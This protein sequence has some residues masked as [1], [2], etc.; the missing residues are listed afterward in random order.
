MTV[1]GI[2]LVSKLSYIISDQNFHTC[3]KALLS[4]DGSTSPRTKNNV[5]KNGLLRKSTAEQGAV[6]VNCKYPK[7]YSKMVK[8]A[9]C[10]HSALI[11]YIHC[12]CILYVI[13]FLNFNDTLRAWLH[14]GFIISSEKL[15]TLRHAHC[16]CLYQVQV[17]YNFPLNLINSTEDISPR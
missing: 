5:V 6:I 4:K 17:R 12:L 16:C 10:T 8:I 1:C 13:Y 2:Q 9:Q 14:L 7:S 3:V 15:R 11:I